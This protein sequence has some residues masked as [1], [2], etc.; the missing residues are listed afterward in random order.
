MR[1]FLAPLLERLAPLMAA[2][3]IGGVAFGPAGQTLAV[4]DGEC[5]SFTGLSLGNDPTQLMHMHLC[6]QGD[7]LR[8]LR[9]SEGEAGTT[10]FHLAGDVD[11]ETYTLWV[12]SVEH[13][14]P[15]PGWMT[16]TDD[17]FHL[18]W[19]SHDE[20]LKG[21][22]VSVDCQDWAQLKLMRD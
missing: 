13:D 1:L 12:T 4:D 18:T 16:C 5:E 15:S 14:A 3:F 9:I 20:Q 6:R 10:V 8:G 2:L 7:D 17:R 22:Y 11:E 19:A 21:H